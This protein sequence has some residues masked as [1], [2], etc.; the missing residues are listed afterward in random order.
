[1][2]EPLSLIRTLPALRPG[3][4]R[5]A[6]TDDLFDDTINPGEVGIKAG[7]AGWTDP[8]LARKGAFY[9]PGLSSAAGRLQF[10]AQN[11]NLV[12]VD[13][14]YYRLP[15]ERNSRLWVERTPSGFTFNVKAFGAFTR[16]PVMADSLPPDLRRL[17]PFDA[18]DK[19]RVSHAAIPEDV[20]KEL[21]RLFRS[22]LLPLHE[23][24]K[25][26]LV[27]FQ[28]P[29][30]FVRGRSSFDYL[31]TL[32]AR[33]P[34]FRIAVE[35]RHHSWLDSARAAETLA[36]LR[37]EG[38]TYTI[39]DEPQGYAS[40]VPFLPAVTTDIAL[41]RLHGRNTDNWDRRGAGVEEKFRYLYPVEE[42]RGFIPVIELL[43]GEARETHVVFNNCYSD[44]AVRNARQL[45]ALLADR[46]EDLT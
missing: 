3:H 28:F 8:A 2:L 36:F 22:A 41:L 44:Y 45:V 14:S 27:L 42:L 25:L 23:A 35:F 46:E 32:Q 16:H 11:F 9:P 10:Y 6:V 7:T 26:G 37:R 33:L 29:K 21:W 13:S 34:E 30:W 15:T 12:E 1:M 24:G 43:R 31:A 39:V 40:S 19:G 20:L 5:G 17:L 4:W 38:L 18:E